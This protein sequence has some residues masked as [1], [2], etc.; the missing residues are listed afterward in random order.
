MAAQLPRPDNGG[1]WNLLD[2][3]TR[4]ARPLPISLSVAILATS[5]IVTL[6]CV[7]LIEHSRG[8]PARCQ[9]TQSQH[10][11]VRS[12]SPRSLPVGAL[13]K[14][15]ANHPG[16][17]AD[18]RNGTSSSV[19]CLAII[20][21]QRHASQVDTPEG[22]V[23]QMQPSLG[24]ESSRSFHCWFHFESP[25]SPSGAPCITT[26]QKSLLWSHSMAVL[27]FAARPDWGASPVRSRVRLLRHFVS[28]SGP[29][30]RTLRLSTTSA[31]LSMGTTPRSKTLQ[32]EGEIAGGRG[33]WVPAQPS[34]VRRLSRRRPPPH[35]SGH[36][37]SEHTGDPHDLRLAMADWRSPDHSGTGSITEPS[38]GSLCRGDGARRSS[39]RRDRR[40]CRGS[41]G[42][43]GSENRGIHGSYVLLL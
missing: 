9:H 7:H 34:S 43:R 24:P 28:R 42:N 5:W 15:Q 14:H 11:P 18:G 16:A 21:Q 17:K 4:Q 39:V 26:Y 35:H 2:T 19:W 13:P 20:A 29:L 41:L 30:L 37:T 1:V 32:R 31:V 40:H 10:S 25:S 12:H 38:T 33:F 22:K 23:T 6:L 36:R 27:F 3:G 8:T